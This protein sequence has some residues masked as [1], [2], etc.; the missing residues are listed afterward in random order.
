M[1]LFQGRFTTDDPLLSSGVPIEPRSWN[2]Y[3]YCLNSPLNYIDPKGLIW[4]TRTTVKDNVSTT[5]YKWVWQDDPEEGWNAVTDFWVD[6]VGPDGQTLGLRLNPQGPK[7]FEQRVLE[8]YTALGF[9][10]ITMITTI[11]ATSTRPVLQIDG[12]VAGLT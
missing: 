8:E 1:R 11:K 7:S 5:E 4:Q 2:R 9:L 10:P 12:G 6:V 3:T